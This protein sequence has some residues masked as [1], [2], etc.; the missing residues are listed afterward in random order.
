MRSSG[1]PPKPT[2]TRNTCASTAP[3]KCHGSKSKFNTGNHFPALT[4]QDASET[5]AIQRLV[6][7]L[8]ATG[9]A[10]TVRG[11]P[12]RKARDRRAVDFELEVNGD[13]VGVEVTQLFLEARQWIETSRLE[14]RLSDALIPFAVERQLGLFAVS[15]AWG[16]LPRR[17]EL[18][19]LCK[20]LV[21]L[22]R[23]AMVRLRTPQE[24]WRPE[25]LP[26]GIEDLE[27]QLISFSTN[28]VGFVS[29]AVEAYWV[30]LTAAEYVEQLIRSKA[31]QADEYEVAW[32]LVVETTPTASTHD[33]SAAFYQVRDELPRNWRRIYL[34]PGDPDADPIPLF[35][36]S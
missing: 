24:S 9:E 29:S 34:I 6:S 8:E 31:T 20:E 15:V 14:R 7:Y 30:E 2:P 5:A 25:T 10:V 33:L 27:I 13:R 19:D 1:A 22:L 16:D 28:S 23:S 12:D 35:T 4:S 36:A 18:E 32:I 17:K 11:R 3:P 26:E 21:Q